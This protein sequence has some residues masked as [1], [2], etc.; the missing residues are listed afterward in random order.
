MLKYQTYLQRIY[1][2]K[3]VLICHFDRKEKSDNCN[4]TDFS[5][6][7]FFEMTLNI[8]TNNLVGCLSRTTNYICLLL[9]ILVPPSELPSIVASVIIVSFPPL[10][11]K[12]IAAKIFGPILPAENCPS[13]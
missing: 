6:E 8:F 13:S 12:F 7:D 9:T 2:A 4:E 5:V 10:L 3:L 11:T 1:S